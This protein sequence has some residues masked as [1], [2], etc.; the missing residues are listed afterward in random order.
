MKPTSTKAR[1]PG[2]SGA[3]IQK[4]RV[5]LGSLDPALALAHSASAPF[6]WRN[7]EAGIAGLARI[8]IGQQVSTASADSIWNRFSAGIGELSAQA[9]LACSIGDLKAFGL[10]SSKAIYVQGIAKALTTGALDFERLRV[11]EDED[12]IAH[13]MALKGVG[14]WTAEVYLMFCEGRTDVFPAGDLALQ[15][16]FRCAARAALR[17]SATELCARA[18]RWRPHRGVAAHLLWSYYRGVKGDTTEMIRD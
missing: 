14:R 15:E 6:E 7:R 4:I 17:P 8:V 9:I 12:A 13:L 5:L 16:A 1:S 18:E 3:E 11:L 10:S 2:H